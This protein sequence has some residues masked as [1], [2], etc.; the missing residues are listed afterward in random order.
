MFRK[1]F[2]IFLILINFDTASAQ[3]SF[4]IIPLGIL[5]GGDESNLSAYLIAPKSQNA[6]ISLDAGTIKAGINK[7]IQNKAFKASA[8]KILQDSIKGYLISHGH[9]DHLA[10]LILNAPD[11]SPKP[12][13][14]MPYVIEVLKKHYFS[15]ESW[16]NFA[17]EGEK[18]ALGKYQYVA[19]KSYQEEKLKATE[20]HVTAFPLSH[21]SPYES[22]AFLIRHQQDYLLYLGDT[23][24]DGIEK[25]NKLDSL[26]KFI[27]PLIQSKALKA[28][29]IETSFPNVQADKSLFGHLNPRLLMQEMDRLSLYTGKEALVNF[30]LVITHIKPAGNH[31]QDIK[32]EILKANIL[33]FKLIYPQQGKVLIF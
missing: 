33:K 11:D 6:Y 9:L 3:N 15:W 7:A 29:F 12:I 30:N 2:S 10:G 22:T 19:L 21:V 27:A 4:K 28:I 13:Y 1:L 8:D 24:A 32:N 14:A 18:P 17:N 23:G 16:A 31:T 20:M 25:S 5:G 26:W